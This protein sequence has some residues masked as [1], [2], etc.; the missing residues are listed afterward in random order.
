MIANFNE[1][2]SSSKCQSNSIIQK[3]SRRAKS[4]KSETSE[5]RR[6]RR[7]R[8]RENLEQRKNKRGCQVFGIVEEVYS[9]I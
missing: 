5:S 3:A 1:N 4:R 6:S 2:P 8:S 9:R 7:M